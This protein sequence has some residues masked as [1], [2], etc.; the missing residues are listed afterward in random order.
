M[1]FETAISSESGMRLS[2]LCSGMSVLVFAA[3]KEQTDCR[4]D[5]LHSLFLPTCSIYLQPSFPSTLVEP[6]H[7]TYND[8]SCRVTKRSSERVYQAARPSSR[9]A[10]T[11]LHLSQRM[12]NPQPQPQSLAVLEKMSDCPS[13]DTALRL[14]FKSVQTGDFFSSSYV[15]V[16]RLLHAA[17]PT[18]LEY[19]KTAYAAKSFSAPDTSTPS[20]SQVIFRSKY[21]EIDRT[22]TGILALR[23]I[24]RNDYE[25]FTRNQSAAFK[26]SDTSF[27]EL[28]KF[29]CT[30]T[31][32]FR[33]HQTVFTVL[34]LM[35]TNDLGKSASFEADLSVHLP[36]KIELSQNH[37]MVM[38]Q[39]LRYRADLVPSFAF[40]PPNQQR[41][42]RKLI[43][44]SATFNPA[45]LV[46]AEC[47][48]AAV[49]T[50][51]ELRVSP[52]ELDLK[53]MELYLDV[54]GARGHVNHEGAMTMIEP[55][56]KSF[57][58][59]LRVSS[60]VALREMTAQEAYNTI[61]TERLTLLGYDWDVARSRKAYV[62]ARLFC[63]GR[64]DTQA[65]AEVVNQAYEFL[66]P[67][68]QEALEQGLSV[69]GTVN[70]PAIQSTYMPA[71]FESALRHPKPNTAL[72][73]LLRY[74]S[75]VLHA[76]KE[77]LERV[78]NSRGAVVFER[79]VLDILEPLMAS[80]EFKQNPA[81]VINGDVPLPELTVAKWAVQKS[82]KSIL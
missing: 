9:L 21:E 70:E 18:E 43:Q 39:A 27:K 55:V 3:S 35:I 71:M 74:L 78:P 45:Q 52:E 46:Q 7:S 40:L 11:Q 44:L 31:K 81:A 58:K 19:L 75:R 33:D 76:S 63:M 10:E 15:K 29:F 47:P 64:I 62:K 69:Y 6:Y 49:D 79:N 48:P 17:F 34:F 26:L 56:L 77:T 61:L 65:S 54:A 51:V 60:R 13:S 25:S 42:V 8:K 4:S 53:F 37:D 41:S 66:D 36:S 30:K 1:D 5:L 24:Y 73:P 50:L 23:W 20:P 59:A 82:L 2:L 57:Q 12:R 68:V 67:T 32:N 80:D 14:L 16:L 22:L 72:V 38:S 28:R